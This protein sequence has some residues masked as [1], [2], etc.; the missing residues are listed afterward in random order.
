MEKIISDVKIKVELV[1][2]HYT[3][4]IGKN[5]ILDDI[6]L[7]LQSGHIYGLKGR[8]G[9]GKTMLM[10]A[11]CGLIYPTSGS[12]CLD[13]KYLGKDISFPKSAGVLIENPAF[14]PNE[15]GLQNLMDLASLKKEAD[16][17]TV[18]QAIREVGLDPDDR[19][20]YRKYSLGMKQRLGIAAVFME[21]PD[22][23]ILDEPTN[24]LDESG[25]TL[26]KP[27]LE[28]ER[29][30]GALI[31][32]S[33]HDTEDLYA[34]ADQIILIESGKIVKQVQTKGEDSHAADFQTGNET[35]F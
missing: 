9:S 33:C 5:L 8:N 16:L 24:A 14:L 3:K 35:G 15:T 17:E 26:L 25:I 20:K 28:R 18:K 2:S 31:L 4:Y 6:S 12:V 10:R 23:I 32:L 11:A 1:F 7:T 27:L 22:L 21:H 30:R 29:E 13:G 19:R 34:L